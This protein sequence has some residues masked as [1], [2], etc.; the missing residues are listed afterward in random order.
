M[1][2]AQSKTFLNRIKALF[3]SNEDSVIELVESCRW[4]G[5]VIGGLGGFA[6]ATW[7]YLRVGRIARSL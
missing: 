5:G 2:V 6:L 7:T 4:P 3:V 1:T